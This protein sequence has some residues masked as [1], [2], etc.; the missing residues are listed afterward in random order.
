MNLAV[1]ANIAKTHLI[2]KKKQTIIASLGVTFGIA[3]FILMIGFMTGVNKF[4]EDSAL[5]STPHLRIYKEVQADRPSVISSL[6]D[7]NELAVVHHQ[8]PK[9]EQLNLKNGFNLVNTLKAMPEVYGVSPQVT[10]QVFYNF[11]PTQISGIL[12][13]VN[14]EDEDKL[15]DIH[16]KIKSGKMDGLLSAKDGVL[17]GVGLAKK[18]NVKT[19]DKVM[20]TTPYG[21][22]KLLRIIGT[23]QTGIGQIDNVRAYC[24]ISTVQIILRKDTRYITDIHMKL[25]D[26]SQ[27]KA[28]G[29]MLNKRYGF[30]AEDWETANETILVSF[31]IR[32]ILT[33]V[34]VMTLLVV[35]GFGIYNIMNMTVVDKMKDIAILKATGFEG[36]DIV[37]IFLMQA[38]FIGILGG[39]VGLI[40]GFILSYLLS[41]TPFNAGEFMAI[42]TFP[43]NFDPKFYVFGL[44][45][46]L[47]TT[48]LA[49]YFPS[50]KASKIDP[51]NIL[52]G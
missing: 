27:S 1:S 51:V 20:V 25:K 21:N 43:V 15:Y 29:S 42:D 35:A 48:V 4:L 2:A 37:S 52:R 38:M 11:G 14:I 3:M 13:G 32:N 7:S 33:F 5:T 44:V 26:L 40:I 12:V 31:V 39:V 24:N 10:T 9:D 49:G 30:K 34:V 22:T 50:K 19:G 17:M 18:M 36:G 45:F 46:G 23:F 8:K 16:S 41:I 28:L 6:V 47:V